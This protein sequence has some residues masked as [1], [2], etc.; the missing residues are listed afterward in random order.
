MNFEW[1]KDQMMWIEKVRQFMIDL[2]VENALKSESEQ[3]PWQ[4]RQASGKQG[5]IGLDVPKEYGGEGLSAVTMGLLYEECGKFGV[6]TREV[7]G[8]GHGNMIAKFGTHEQKSRYLPSLIKGDLLVGVGLTEPNCGSD[9]AAIETFARKDGSNYILSG[10]KEWVSRVEEAGVFVVF[11]QTKH[12][13]GTKGLTAFLVDMNDPNI[14]KYAL[15]PM[16]MKGWSYGGFRLHDVVIPAENRLGLE[17]EGFRIFNQHFGYWRVL[18]GII[19]VGAARKA[20]EQGVQYAKERMAFGGPIGRFQSVMHKIAEH[21]TL[22]E[23]A[24][25]LS[26]K[27]LDV[28]DR[29]HSNTMEASMAKWYSTT[30]A[31]KAI[32]DMLQIHG[33][34]GYVKEYGLEQKL[35][36]VRGL[37]IADGSTDVLKSLIGRDLMGREIYDAMLGRAREEQ[38]LRVLNMVP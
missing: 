26:L 38:P 22:L 20:L 12:G 31:Y 34:R 35:R 11:A 33:A 3:L 19:C 30:T 21:A 32:D 7:I 23:T 37:M 14:E 5:L 15:E 2:D 6:N 9:L 25:L 17:G 10:C 28:L 18:M 4:I 29:G 27:A 1:T 8:A 24:S 13:S 16:G 36:D